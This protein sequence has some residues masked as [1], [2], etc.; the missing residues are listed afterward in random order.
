[1]LSI[2]TRRDLATFFATLE[3]NNFKPISASSIEAANRL[4]RG[5]VLV[6]FRSDDPLPGELPTRITIHEDDVEDFFAWAS[7][8]VDQLCPLTA[9]VEVWSR[10]EALEER[11]PM[12]LTPRRANA[13]L[14]AALMDG[15]LQ[16]RARIRIPDT[17]LPA[18]LRTLSVIFLQEIRS[19]S[20]PDE[21]SNAAALWALV[22]EALHSGEMPF[23]VNHVL[24]FWGQVVPSFLG[25]EQRSGESELHRV[26]GR[27]F[28]TSSWD[29]PWLGTQL[30]DLK[31]LNVDRILRSSREER[32]RF[33][34]L[35][36]SELGGTSA[37][38][39]LRAAFGGYLLSLVA[40]GDF[41]LWSTAID[42]RGMPTL[43]LWF[44][45]FAGGS[46]RTNLLNH[47]QSVA[48]RL[49]TLMTNSI[50]SCDIDARELIISKRLK[51]RSTVDFPL[52]SLNILKAR[53]SPYVYGWFPVR[54]APA[55]A[56]TQ[57]DL[58]MADNRR[59]SPEPQ[60][61][62]NRHMQEARDLAERLFQLLTKATIPPEPAPKVDSG[63]KQ[64]E[65][66]VPRSGKGTGSRRR[67]KS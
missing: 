57:R 36:L 59:P 58:A 5:E 20:A 64:L 42:I 53:L 66:E 44:G 34:D 49:L 55:T 40:D 32:L 8:Y 51:T 65:L 7:T 22:R 23:S 33:A 4:G 47:N 25:S 60:Y 17:I 21:I 46:E 67:K 37:D 14:G 29:N 45:I 39:E 28:S 13:I 31:Q 52:S 27:Y 19:G 16:S 43:P 3:A 54:E 11:K 30:N 10:R 35:I 2:A 9:F 15:L 38:A 62:Q 41:S 56:P 18:T 26:L 12:K 1:M 50:D 24:S 48:R 6:D 63:T 61:F